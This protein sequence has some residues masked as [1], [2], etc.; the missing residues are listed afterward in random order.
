M[1]LWVKNKFKKHATAVTSHLLEW[2]RKLYGHIFLNSF[3]EEYQRIA[4]EKKWKGDVPLDPEEFETKTIIVMEVQW[5]ENY[6][7]MSLS[8]T[9]SNF[10]AIEDYFSICYFKSSASRVSFNKVP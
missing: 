2:S 5:L 3:L 6:N 10:V 8:T 9:G 4:L 1:E 7:I